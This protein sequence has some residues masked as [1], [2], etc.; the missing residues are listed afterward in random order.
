MVTMFPAGVFRTALPLILA[1]VYLHVIYAY[2]RHFRWARVQ[3]DFVTRL[4]ARHSD[5]IVIFAAFF[6][7]FLGMV[8][9]AIAA[10]D[11]SLAR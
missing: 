8:F 3:T 7:D 6:C 1:G 2:R 4:F 5:S 9:Y 10:I 11:E